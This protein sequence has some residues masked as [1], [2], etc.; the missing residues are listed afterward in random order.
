MLRIPHCLDSLL[1]DGGEIAS[2]TRGP[3]FTPQDHS[4]V[5]MVSLIEKCIDLMGDGD[6]FG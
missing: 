3:P 5:G 4:L 6:P 1:T 2:L